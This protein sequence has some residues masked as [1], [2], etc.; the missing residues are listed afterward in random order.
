[1]APKEAGIKREKEK[2]KAFTGESPT[3]KPAKK[4]EPERDTPGRMAID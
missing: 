3:S 1:M 2:L 4:D